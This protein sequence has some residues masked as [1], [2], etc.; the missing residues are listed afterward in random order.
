MVSQKLQNLDRALQA[1]NKAAF[2]FRHDALRDKSDGVPPQEYW[3][4]TVE[5]LADQFLATFRVMCDELPSMRL[6]ER[7]ARD[8]LRRW[9]LTEFLLGVAFK[10][11]QAAAS[12]GQDAHRQL[13]YTKTIWNQ[14]RAEIEEL[15]AQQLQSEEL[16]QGLKGWLDAVAARGSTWEDTL[17]YMQMS[18]Y[19]AIVKEEARQNFYKE[20]RARLEAV[21]EKDVQKEV[22]ECFIRA[23][24]EAEERRL[25]YGTDEAIMKAVHQ[26]YKYALSE[27]EKRLDDL[28][29]MHMS[30]DS[31]FAPR[32]SLAGIP[33]TP[34][35]TLLLPLFMFSQSW[36][37]ACCT[38]CNCKFRLQW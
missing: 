6:A 12:E 16:V 21:T 17:P 10:K 4:L 27:E 36:P 3:T 26:A 25:V 30:L 28:A 9:K 33:S 35:L 11:V 19:S 23:E 38:R 24:W 2:N 1:L 5:P 37:S 13:K 14:L 29:A 8:E 20:R 32:T 31:D 34:L 18:T 7:K 22:N 15:K